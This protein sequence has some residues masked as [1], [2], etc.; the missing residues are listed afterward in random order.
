MEGQAVEAQSLAEEP[1]RPG[2]PI[3]AVAHDSMAREA[4]VA[5]DLMLAAGPKVALNQGVMGASPENTEARLARDC[6]AGTFG[7]EASTRFLGQG[8]GPEPP[9]VFCL[10]LGEFSVEEGDITLPDLVVLEL[11]GEVGESFR[12]AS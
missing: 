1:E 11:F 9:T 12:S 7:T 3:S 10:R 6:L 4:G 8:P 2:C 5:P